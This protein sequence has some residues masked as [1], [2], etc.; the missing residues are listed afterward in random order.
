MKKSFILSF[1]LGCSWLFSP[2]ALSIAGNS[3]GQL[4]WPVLAIL[5]LGGLLFTAC[6]RLLASPQLPMAANR[7]FLIL[8]QTLTTIPATALTLAACLPLAGLAATALLVSSGYTFNEV[9]LYWFPNF[10]F[11]F[12]LL[13]LL[14]VLQLFPE[15]IILRAQLCFIAVCM[16][17][18]LFLSVYGL[19]QGGGTAAAAAAVESTAFT[20]TSVALPLL[21]FV[22]STFP[23]G[24]DD[25][26]VSLAAPV[27]VPVVGILVYILWMSASLLYVEPQRLASSTIPYMT[28]ARKILAD[29]GRQI[30]GIV[31]ISGS[32]AAIN[33]IL[34]LCRRLLAGLA[35][36]GNNSGATAAR[37]LRWLLPPFFA[38]CTG[39]MMATGLAGDELLEVL[40]RGALILWL[41]YYCTLCLSAFFRLPKEE[42][43]TN[44]TA[45]FSSL[46]LLIGIGTLIA[47]DPRRSQLLLSIFAAFA[48]SGLLAS[49]WF[50]INTLSKTK[51]T[52]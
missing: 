5:A 15:R 13:A 34:L 18:L 32:C 10:G 39:A 44:L 11:A 49:C 35:D 17:G 30:M 37:R 6:A 42:K 25:T 23:R 21:L 29:P 2:E 14:T 9:F 41:L 22:A 7:E 51:Q 31:V 26:P 33:G 27:L 43:R 45:V 48:G 52:P 40:L 8:R 3:S 20:P 50:F 28:A 47:G 24:Q 46:I 38:V 4:G 12:L 16:G 1:A 36:Q 19:L